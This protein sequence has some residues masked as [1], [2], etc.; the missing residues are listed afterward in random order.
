MYS[1]PLHVLLKDKYYDAFVAGTKRYEVRLSSNA[2]YTPQKVFPGREV[3]LQRAYRKVHALGVVGEVITG[4]IDEILEIVD[5][6][7]IDPEAGTKDELAVE[8][9]KMMKCRQVKAQFVAFEI[10]LG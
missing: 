10:V 2:M 4:T 3:S 5:F 7:L 6:R 1:K 8:V 9:L